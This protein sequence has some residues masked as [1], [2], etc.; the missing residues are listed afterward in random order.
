METLLE[1][2]ERT[3]LPLTHIDPAALALRARVLLVVL[4]GSFEK[5][6]RVEK[7]IHLR[8]DALFM[9]TLWKNPTGAE[10]SAPC[11]SRR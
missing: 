4:D 10:V 5:A 1:P 8:K 9:W 2:A 11:S 7:Y 6:L 3:A